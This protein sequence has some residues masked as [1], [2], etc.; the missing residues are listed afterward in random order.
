VL[1]LID[2]ESNGDPS[3]HRANSQYYGLLQIGKANAA[4]LGKSNRDFDGDGEA[5]LEGFFRYQQ[6]YHSRTG[7]DP[8]LIALLWKGGP[9]TVRTYTTLLRER[10]LGPAQ[11]FLASRWGGS[12]L[13][14]LRRFSADA[15]KWS[16]GQAQLTDVA[17]VLPV[18][19]NRVNER[20]GCDSRATDGTDNIGTGAQASLQSSKAAAQKYLNANYGTSLNGYVD[21]DLPTPADPAQMGTPRSL[22]Y[23][24][25]KN[26]LQSFSLNFNDEPGFDFIWPLASFTVGDQFGKVRQ[27]AV[28]GGRNPK[29]LGVDAQGRQRTRRHKGIDLRTGGNVNQPV[30]A[31]AAGE[32][33]LAGAL[34]G[35]GYVVFISHDN[36]ITTR[37]AHLSEIFA[38]VG[39]VFD[40]TVIGT[41]DG[42]LGNAGTTE[43]SK[44][45]GRLVTKHNQLTIPH[46]HFELRVNKGVIAGG[47]PTGGLKSNGANYPVDA[48]PLLQGALLPGQLQ[49]RMDTDTKA[50]V[51][52][53]DGYGELLLQA[54]TEHAAQMVVDAYDFYSAFYRADLMGKA[55]RS[56][57]WD[58][59]K[60][61][62][63]QRQQRV[64]NVTFM[65]ESDFSTSEVSAE[66][67]VVRAE[68]A[69]DEV[70]TAASA[71]DAAAR[72]SLIEAT[73]KRITELQSRDPQT[74]ATRGIIRVQE[75][76]LAL[77]QAGKGTVTSSGGTI[78]FNSG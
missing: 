68:V 78:T 33:I 14:Y 45:G 38:K 31:V 35:Y 40:S 42:I 60:T 75:Q 23:I 32:V 56:T 46:L 25:N 21:P 39:D 48:A 24:D 44:V 8:Q 63:V 57:Y 30:Y 69:P 51:D 36:G 16:E 18:A 37:Y 7:Y 74:S 19:G 41:G 2:V 29:N 62:N 6:M 70:A 58:L 15:K 3:A 67:N 54:E 52:A 49:E 50:L 71:D 13:V 59:E 9:G 34:D 17:V 55:G 72:N 11:A 28:G 53:R 1:S 66:D 43:S 12:P 4:D 73:K 10:G 76:K 5:S 64:E 22:A 26:A 20:I 77:L 65:N 27:T 47:V 61:Q